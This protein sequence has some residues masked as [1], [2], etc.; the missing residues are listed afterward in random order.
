MREISHL[1][2]SGV[3]QFMEKCVVFD[4]SPKFKDIGY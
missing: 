2:N 3:N 4:V 1:L